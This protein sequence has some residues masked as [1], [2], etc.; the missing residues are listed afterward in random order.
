M[1]PPILVVG[2]TGTVGTELVPELV[3][4]GQ[5]VRVLARDPRR[6]AERLGPQ[7]EI[8]AGDL[9]DPTSLAS[10][11]EGVEVASLA[12]TPTPRLHEL[13][14][15]FIAAAS[16]AKLRRL[17]K[18]SA[19]GIDFARDRIHLAHAESER[20]L[21]ASGVAHVV[22]RP[23][24]FMSNLLFEAAAIRTGRLPSSFGDGR[25]SFVDPRDVAELMARALIE[26]RHEGAIWEL[27]GP[28]A[29]SY[30]ELAATLTRVLHRRVEHV[31]LEP[32][33]F[34]E[35]ALS[36][37]LPHFVVESIVD[38]AVHTR[39]GKFATNDDVVLRVLG[40]RAHDF[41]DWVA[42]HRHAFGVG[43]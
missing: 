18:L 8:V 33:A 39:A 12:T 25:M 28:A 6:A 2:A 31:R 10:A 40:R 34:S 7:V 21:R 36:A 15:N 16:A 19:F 5:D 24:V 32:S 22:V 4:L 42:R 37:G 23:V 1:A 13:E 41:G 26:P 27:G 29:L 3:R 9:L 35:A 20:L 38:T 11:L 30:D 14:G 17:V 43:S